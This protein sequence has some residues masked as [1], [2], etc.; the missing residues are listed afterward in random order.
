MLLASKPAGT[1]PILLYWVLA[2]HTANSLEFPF[3]GM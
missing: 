1:D 2:N 3:G